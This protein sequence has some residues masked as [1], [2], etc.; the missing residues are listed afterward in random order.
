MG[1]STTHKAISFK[2]DGEQAE[3]LDGIRRL[4]KAKTGNETIRR[5]L[6]LAAVLLTLQENGGKVL[7]QDAGGTIQQLIII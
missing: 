1:S 4:M 7:V 2:F 3:Q 6:N 5:S